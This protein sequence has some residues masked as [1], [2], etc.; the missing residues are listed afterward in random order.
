MGKIRP[1]EYRSPV[2][3]RDKIE[4]LLED[5]RN[6]L[7]EATV[8]LR[9]EQMHGYLGKA[10]NAMGDTND[11]LTNYRIYNNHLKDNGR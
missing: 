8:L 6:A 9:Q 10:L 1:R 5:A 4:K 11:C 2:Q 3:R 7:A